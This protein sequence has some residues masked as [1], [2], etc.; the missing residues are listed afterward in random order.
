MAGESWNVLSSFQEMGTFSK[1]LLLPGFL[2]VGAVL[3]HGASLS[4]RLLPVSLILISFSLAVH[5]FSKSRT[6]VA[7]ANQSVTVFDKGKIWSG[8]TMVV[9]T[10]GLTVWAAL[11]PFQK[12][13]DAA[14]TTDVPTLQ[15]ETT[16]AEKTAVP[17]AEKTARKEKGTGRNSASGSG[18]Q[19]AG[20]KSA[21]IGSVTQRACSALQA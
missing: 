14:N 15:K 10:I 4:D 1:V 13:A 9:I 2:F 6:T 11:I 3:V 21:A 16:P 5:Y 7:D 18:T 19:A 12:S 8:I 17:A 20:D